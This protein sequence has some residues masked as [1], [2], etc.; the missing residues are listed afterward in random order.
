MK[1][2]RGKELVDNAIKLFDWKEKVLGILQEA[3]VDAL[4]SPIAEIH[5]VR[6]TDFKYGVNFVNT[7]FVNFLGFTAGVVPFGRVTEDDER[8][9]YKDYKNDELG[10]GMKKAIAGST[11]LPVAVQLWSYP[12]RESLVLNLM[13]QV[14]EEVKERNNYH[15]NL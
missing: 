9:A 5:A 3:E 6:V 4:L 14:E 2:A 8:L 10:K 1:A 13:K 15:A 12:G 7:S 11:G